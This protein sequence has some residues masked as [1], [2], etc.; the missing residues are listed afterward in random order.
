[1][2]RVCKVSKMF[3]AKIR[4]QVERYVSEK[5]SSNPELSSAEVL[6]SV[7]T[8]FEAVLPGRECTAGPGERCLARVWGDI[9]NIIYH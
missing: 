6:E 2:L 8:M 4:S 5:R 9:L 7:L 1:M 3:S